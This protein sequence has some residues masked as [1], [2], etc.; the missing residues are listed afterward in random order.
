MQSS[1]QGDK[2]YLHSALE[3]LMVVGLG[4]KD[5][6]EMQVLEKNHCWMGEFLQMS[7]LGALEYLGWDEIGSS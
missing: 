3:Q 6:K 5:F 2:I 4:G 7:E 1:R